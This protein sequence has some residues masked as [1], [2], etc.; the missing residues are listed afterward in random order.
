M[1]KVFVVCWGMIMV[2]ALVVGFASRTPLNEG[3]VLSV[4]NY[5]APPAFPVRLAGT[6]DP[7]VRA[8]YVILLD[9]NTFY[10]LYKKEAYTPVPIASTTKMMT[11]LVV[12]ERYKLEDVIKIS[13][14][15]AGQIGSTTGLVVGEAITVRSLL[16]ALLIQSGNDAAY[17]LAEHGGSVEQFV[18]WM[19]EKAAEIGM[20]S[21]QF[22]D[23]A[24]L[25]DE[26]RSTAFDLGILAATLAQDK[27]VTDIAMIPEALITSTDGRHRHLLKNSNR[28]VTEEMYFPGAMGMKTGFTPAAG[29]TLVAVAERD[30]K[31]LVSVVLFTFDDTKEASARET[32]KLLSWGFDNHQ[33]VDR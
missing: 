29:H 22:K 13:R 14:K 17:A 27:R 26:G 1:K 18:T 31:R 32:Y 23:P 30:G 9:A 20:R 21:T 19:N 16:K 5:P 33:W 7:A 24:G 25:D 15:A 11:A 4:Q 12:M 2:A 10:P 28:L 6:L 8:K 3:K